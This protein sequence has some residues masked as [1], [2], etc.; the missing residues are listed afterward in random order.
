[1][2]NHKLLSVENAGSRINLF[3]DTQIFSLKPIEPASPGTRVGSFNDLINE[4]ITDFIEITTPVNDKYTS[5][6]YKIMSK[7]GYVILH[8]VNARGQNVKVEVT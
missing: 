8:W 2:K 5:F 3:T 1:M 4:T 7:K 6:A